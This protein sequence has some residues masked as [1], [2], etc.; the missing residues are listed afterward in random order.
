MMNMDMDKHT[1]I[2]EKIANGY[3]AH[4]TKNGVIVGTKY[5]K[6]LDTE[7]LKSTLMET[8]SEG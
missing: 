5:F 1:V 3:L 7:E 4:L 2:L 6:S 8:L